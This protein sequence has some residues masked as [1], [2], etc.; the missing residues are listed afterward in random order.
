MILTLTPNPSI[1]TTMSLAAPLQR[2]AVQRPAATAQTAG[3]KGV[4]VTHALSLAGQESLALVPA[5]HT[6]PFLALALEAG[7]P[8]DSVA[9]EEGVRMNTTIAE[10]DGTTT[11]LNGPGAYL[12]EHARA[13]LAERIAIYGEASSWLA[14]AGSLPPGAPAGWYRE[15]LVFLRERAP[16]L[17]TAVDTSG[18]S[19]RDLGENLDSAAPTLLKPNSFEL[20]QLLGRDGASLEREALHGEFGPVIAAGREVL[21]RGVPE[22]LVTLGAGGAILIVESGVWHAAAPQ[23]AV[24]STVG[25]GDAS[26]AGYLLSR[27]RG[28]TPADNVTWAVAY[29]AAAATLPGSRMPAPAEVD[30]TSV[31]VTHLD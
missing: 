24:R 4:N 23:V 1:D 19:I 5:P 9:V 30:P 14:M 13:E 7:F 29:G 8:F 12:G 21:E 15:L 6:D 28:G 11:K 17:K 2:G 31:G 25:A 20:G 27:I 22:V 3:G 16:H 18:A 10:P 26:M